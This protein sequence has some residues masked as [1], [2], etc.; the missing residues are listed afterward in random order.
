MRQ[1]KRLSDSLDPKGR[2]LYILPLVVFFK[3]EGEFKNPNRFLKDISILKGRIYLKVFQIRDCH[4][5][6]PMYFLSLK[7]FFLGETDHISPIF[8]NFPGQFYSFTQQI[9]GA[10]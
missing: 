10:T 6:C 5:F 3:R 1:R 9:F 4:P 8:T 2:F 7:Y